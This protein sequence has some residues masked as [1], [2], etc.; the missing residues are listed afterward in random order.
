MGEVF[1]RL[2]AAF[3]TDVSRA[4][5]MNIITHRTFVMAISGKTQ[6]DD[7]GT[8]RENSILGLSSATPEGWPSPKASGA[9]FV[10]GWG[11][12][13]QGTGQSFYT[14]QLDPD[15]LEHSFQVVLPKLCNETVRNYR[16]N[17]FATTVWHFCVQFAAAIHCRRYFWVGAG[18][19]GWC[20]S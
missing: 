8:P 5:K 14:G 3:D 2:H 6:S 7:G 18:E 1:L 19:R 17:T 13:C 12:R 10:A 9:S 11:G 15:V 4:Q 20:C 16:N